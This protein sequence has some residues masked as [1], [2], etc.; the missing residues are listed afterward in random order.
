VN[1]RLLIAACLMPIVA[2]SLGAQTTN[3]AAASSVAPGEPD[4]IMPQVILQ[5]EDLSVEKVQAQLP[6]Q[7]DLLPPQRK[8]PVLSEGELAIGEPTIPA[9]AVESEALAGQPHDRLLAANVDVGAGNDNRLVANISLKTL[10]QDPRFSLLFNHETL[11]G[12]SSKPAGCG[13]SLRNDD[14]EGNLNF[15]LGGVDTAL[16]GSF[17]ENETGLQSQPVPHSAR[18]GRTLASS[19]AFSATPLDWLTLK[20]AIEGGTD[21]LVLQ[22]VNPYELDGLRVAPSLA[23][24]GHFGS[25]KVGLSTRYTYRADPTNAGG[26]LHRVL[27][28]ASFSADLPAVFVL[29]GSVGWFWNSA[30]LSLVPFSLSLTGTPFPFLTLSA[31]G[32]YRVTPYDMHDQLAV[33]PLVLP[34][35]LQDDRGWFGDS[36]LQFTFSRDL[37][38]TVKVSFMASDAMPVGA[39]TM[40]GATGLFPM[41]QQKGNLFSTDAGVRWSI[42]SAFSLS[43]GWVHQFLD[44]PFYQPIDMIQ[45]ELVGL[46]STGRFGGSL[47]LSFSPTVTGQLQQ[48]L[49]GISG[50]WKISDSVKLH[51]DGDDLLWPFV[52]G[53]RWDIP[54]YVTPGFRVLGSLSVSL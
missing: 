38:A 23:A 3:A 29:D 33:H 13:F 5:I 14:L 10:G 9:A 17:L 2:L 40:D 35:G 28:S 18:L 49:L 27:T 51:L 4:M 16:K 36:N 20:G 8:I 31:S 19:A 15:R 50:F 46:E 52:G 32:G 6:P 41:G 24:E 42:S 12:F 30:S 26:Q 53:S 48:P 47:S 7:E 21:S 37:A 43:A 25:V 34:T 1:V 11:D 39:T 22:G 54:P 44:R 45:G